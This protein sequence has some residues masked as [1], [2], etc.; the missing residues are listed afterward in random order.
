[1]E[2]LFDS[3]AHYYDTRFDKEF[4]STD[5]LLQS[6]FALDAAAIVNIGTDVENSRGVVAEA[7]RGPGMYATVGIH[8]GDGERIED[9][10]TALAEIEAMLGTPETRKRDKIVALGEIGLDYHYEETNREKQA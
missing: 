10:D 2:K 1:M 9:I 5:A 6:L 7:A 4:G 8:P 3:H